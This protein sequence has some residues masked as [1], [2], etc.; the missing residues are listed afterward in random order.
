M[1][2]RELNN[3]MDLLL[4]LQGTGWLTQ[5]ELNASV[6]VH[7]AIENIKTF[8]PSDEGNN[9][10]CSECGNTWDTISPCALCNATRACS[11]GRT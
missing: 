5:D 7:A 10:K 4:K 9:V 1:E 8:P 6:V 3:L 2:D 11:S